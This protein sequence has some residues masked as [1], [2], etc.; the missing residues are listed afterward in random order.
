MKSIQQI[1][2]E[3]KPIHSDEDY[4]VY[5]K[6]ID[7]LVDCEENSPEEELLELISIIVEDYESVHFA[8]EPPDPVEAIKLKMEENGLKKKDLV[9]YFGSASRVSEVLNRK[10]PLTLEMIRR[11]H[12]GLGISAATLLAS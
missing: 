4:K 5:L 9:D 10:R 1:K 7:S 6:V 8:I 11:I 3:L 2:S 12:K